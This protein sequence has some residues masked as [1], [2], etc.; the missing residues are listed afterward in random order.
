MVNS[1]IGIIPAAGSGIR[2][3]P[4]TYEV[5]KGMFLIDGKPNIERHV[6]LMRDEAGI[7]EIVIVLGYMAGSIQEYFGDGSDFGVRITYVENQHLDKGWAWSVLLAKPYM[8]GRRGLVMLADEFY[9]N[10]NLGEIIDFDNERFTTVLPVKPVEDRELI[11]KNFS[12]DRDGERIIRLVEN[13]ISTPNDLLGMA[14]FVIHPEVLVKLEEAYQSGR[15]SLDFITFVDDLIRD[16][17]EVAAFDLE[18][19][20]LNLNDVTSME[21]AQDMA[22]RARL[23]AS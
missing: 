2:A 13:P 6:D 21:A 8:A 22:I 18:G 7:E 5:H 15:T 14:S 10:T 9:L 17:H 11:K 20:Y 12:V 19:D 16:G 1:L 4:Y 3:R 23:E